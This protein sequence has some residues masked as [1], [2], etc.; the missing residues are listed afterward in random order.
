MVCID[1]G[2]LH[3]FDQVPGQEW[4]HTGFNLVYH[5]NSPRFQSSEPHTDARKESLCSNRFLPQRKPE[6]LDVPS[7]VSRVC[8]AEM[9]GSSLEPVMRMSLMPRS[10]YS[11][12]CRIR[13]FSEPPSRMADRAASSR[14]SVPMNLSAFQ[15][16]T[17]TLFRFAD[18]STRSSWTDTDDFRQFVQQA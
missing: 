11:I 13:L 16:T 9:I 14:I 8:S 2:I 4:V 5:Q 15:R 18:S 3:H 17:D 12:S 1:G 7:S 10:A 6:A